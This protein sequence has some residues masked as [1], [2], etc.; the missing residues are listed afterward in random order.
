MNKLVVRFTF[1][2]L[3]FFSFCKNT[4]ESIYVIRYGQSLFPSERVSK[5]YKKKFI[6]LSWLLYYLEDREGHKILIDTGIEK[7]NHASL[8]GISH[9]EPPTSIL[10]ANLISPSSITDIFITHWHLDHIG[11]IGEYPNANLFI[12]KLEYEWILRN[13]DYVTF[14]NFLVQKE[15][16]KKLFLV[17]EELLVYKIFLL[18][19][20]GGHSKGSLV[21]FVNSSS[22]H[23]IFTGDECYFVE[24]CKNKKTL[25]LSV[26][27][28]STR[29]KLFIDS[30]E[31]TW[32]LLTMHDPVISDSSKPNFFRLY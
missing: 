20:V 22:S 6:S 3:I 23:F 19:W 28:S 4:L 11:G 32:I 25:P 29:N 2:I 9:L 21:V 26:V 7:K 31:E 16:Q 15:K 27:Y 12:H 18:K 24:D 17:N 30:L 8:Y 5:E 1:S 13:P 10:K 14:K